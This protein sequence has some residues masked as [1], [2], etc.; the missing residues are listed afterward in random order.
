VGELDRSLLV[1]LRHAR[2]EVERALPEPPA[3]QPPRR[4]AAVWAFAALAL[5]AA[6]LAGALYRPAA[7]E[8]A[9]AE[10]DAPALAEPAASALPA[11]PPG[12]LRITGHV[13]AMQ[14]SGIGSVVMGRV[15]EVL[16]EEGDTVVAGQPLVR[17]DEASARQAVA[18]AEARLEKLSALRAELSLR[19]TDAARKLERSSQLAASGYLSDEALDGARLARAEVDSALEQVSADLKEG[20][21]ALASEQERLAEHVLRAPFAG[22]VSAVAAQLGQVLVPAAPDGFVRTGVVT[23]YSPASVRIEV[24]VA[25][26]LYPQAVASACVLV[27]SPVTPER[28]S[29]PVKI[30]QVAPTADRRQGT[31]RLLFEAREG[32]VDLAP[33]TSVDVQF[34]DAAVAG[35]GGDPCQA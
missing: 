25:E 5:S 24:D 11:A 3:G 35:A 23:V 10:A 12:T 9:R 15:S 14:S 22:V 26:P 32:A 27:S 6:S 18:V 31:L 16:V 28:G 30:A 4:H 21:A 17:L 8:T 20:R 13:V 1:R 7:S 33:E 19:R 34:R 2:S 29:I